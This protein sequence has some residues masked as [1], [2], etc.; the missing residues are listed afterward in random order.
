MNVW[1]QPGITEGRAPGA[2]VCLPGGGLDQDF[3]H[4]AAL[5]E[6]C[7]LSWTCETTLIVGIQTKDRQ[8]ELTPA[9]TDPR[10]AE[11]FPAAGGAAD[12][13]RFIIEEVRAF[14]EARYPA[15]RAPP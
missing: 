8:H 12:F 3:R 15:A 6:L 5:G 14:V 4:I 11:G 10:F 7:A 13:R 1:V 2:V 9:A